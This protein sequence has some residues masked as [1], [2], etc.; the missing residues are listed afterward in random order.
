M[1]S[2]LFLLK[3]PGGDL[4]FVL[5]TEISTVSRKKKLSLIY[6]IFQNIGKTKWYIKYDVK[7][8]FHKLKIIEKNEWM[9]TFK[10]KYGFFE[11]LVI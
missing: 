6:E 1:Q 3:K 7:T 9:T 2:Q 8:V 10:T 4:R 11:W 5:I